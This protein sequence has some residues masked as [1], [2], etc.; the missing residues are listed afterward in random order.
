M[1][2]NLVWL[3]LSG[4]V[5]AAI[6]ALWNHLSKR[7]LQRDEAET[8]VALAKLED[9]FERSQRLGQAA[10]DR[11]VFVTRAHFETEFEAMKQVFTHLSQLQ[12][13][14]NGLRP[15]LA[16]ESPDE[17]ETQKVARL[18]ARLEQVFS[19]YNSL[20]AESEAKAPF[21]PAELYS[22]VEECERA[23]SMEINSVRTSG[24]DMF[25]PTWYEEGERNLGRFSK[26]YRKAADTIRER[27]SRLA[28]LPSQ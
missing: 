17:S 14:L 4:L 5:S 7:S 27:I 25:G 16:V 9:K 21:Y 12:I 18:F 3:L 13:G 10:I 2:S 15:I 20:L 24:E 19:S 8:K 23:A 6:S 1:N 22:A 28:I 11:S 26:G